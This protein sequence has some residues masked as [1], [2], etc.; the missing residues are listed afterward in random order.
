MLA[1][2]RVL[3]P[4]ISI[5]PPRAGRDQPRGCTPM[6]RAGF[7]ST[8][9][10]RGGTCMITWC[11]RCPVISIHPPRAGRDG[12]ATRLTHKS[13]ISI[14]PPRA[15]RDLIGW[16]TAQRN[17]GFQSTRP[18]RG[19]TI[20]KAEG[21]I[22]KSYFNPPAPCG[23]GLIQNVN[24]LFIPLFQSPRPVR[25]GTKSIIRRAC[26]SSISI[27]PPHAGRDHKVEYDSEWVESF[28]STRPM[29]GGTGKD[30]G[31]RVDA[32]FQSTRPVRGG[33]SLTWMASLS[34]PDFNPPAPC[35]A[36]L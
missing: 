19:G 22:A 13:G 15:G 21:I 17:V 30:R 25:G 31:G 10:V 29:R 7:Q 16:Q 36:G 28:Q 33:T 9:P 35:G 2:L 8:R 26:S 23:A 12:C 3:M 27:H 1:N 4:D 20:A 14:H 6:G 5:H 32:E 18:V 24:G 34:P 11:A